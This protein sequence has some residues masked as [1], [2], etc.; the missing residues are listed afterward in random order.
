MPKTVI[1]S[2]GGSLVHPEQI[3]VNFLRKF[4]KLILD[5]VNK[6]NRV[7]I[8][9]GGGAMARNYIQA[10]RALNTKATPLE[11]NW[12]GVRTTH[13]NAELVRVMF[14]NVAYSNTI[15]T[16]DQKIPKNFK[17]MIGGGVKPG[18]TTDY[19]T[20]ILAKRLKAKTVV[21][22]SNIDYLY[23]K[24]PRKHKD[25]KV[26]KYISWVDFRKMVGNKMVPGGNYPFD[27]IASRVAHESG[28]EV[29]I[30]NGKN[31]K[32]IQNYLNDKKY[33]GTVIG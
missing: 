29:I 26:I 13:L 27:P 5:F 23:N 33:K 6:G 22:L 24:D 10:A 25:A 15:I 1:F 20:V 17:I 12:I 28:M 9:S 4:K 31:L 8:V 7:V 16:E 14:G 21:N 11:L 2:L 3:D 30:M 18:T 19:N 32:S